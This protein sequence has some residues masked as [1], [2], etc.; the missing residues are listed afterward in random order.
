MSGPGLRCDHQRK[1]PL[2]KK[3]IVQR[4]PLAAT[5][6]CVIVLSSSSLK[7]SISELLSPC[8]G[9]PAPSQSTRPIRWIRAV[10]RCFSSLPIS[11]PTSGHHVYSHR[12][13]IA[14]LQGVK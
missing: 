8:L 7:Q 3:C 9:A 1:Y 6:H 5:H 2:R 13:M 10:S 4:A 14:R 11:A 12:S